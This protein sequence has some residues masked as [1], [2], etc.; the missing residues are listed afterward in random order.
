MYYAISTYSRSQIRMVIILKPKDHNVTKHIIRNINFDVFLVCLF[1][2][3][4][5]LRQGF[6]RELTDQELNM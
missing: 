3:L 4:F 1:V 5:V 2:Y 6:I